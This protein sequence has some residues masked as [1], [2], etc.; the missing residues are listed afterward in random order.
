MQFGDYAEAYWRFQNGGEENYYAQR[1]TVEF[2]ASLAKRDDIESITVISLAPDAVSAEL[3]NGLRTIG[4][5]LYPQRQRPR[6]RELVAAVKDS[7]PTHLIV[8]S[9]I[10]RLIYCG[11]SAGIP[12]L[13]MFADSFRARGL[14]TRVRVWSLVS[15][16]NHPAVTVVANHNLAASLDL[17]RIGVHPSKIVPF[18]W[19]ALLSPGDYAPKDPSTGNGPFRL[20]FVGSLIEAKGVGDAIVGLG[21]LRRRG[22]N[23]TLTLIGRGDSERFQSLAIREQIEP[24]VSFAGPKSHK[25]VLAAMRDH[26]AVL[27]PSHWAFPEGLPM[28]IYESLCVRTPVLVS[29]HPMFAMKIRDRTNALVFPEQNPRALAACVERL[30]DSPGLYVQMS[31]ASGMALEGYLCPLK[32]DQLITDFI[33]ASDRSRLTE[34]TLGRHAYV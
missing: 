1:Y 6:F 29:D 24:Y 9:P 14:W 4:L 18:D 28:T 27:V 10:A 13:P 5:E 3:P 32:F 19:P 20:L 23:V 31:N 15:L 22:R 30:I 17:K 16:L 8:M 11:L 12:T 7:R 2:I 26:D 21:H 33:S 34:Y 25:E